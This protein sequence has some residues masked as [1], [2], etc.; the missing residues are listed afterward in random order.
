MS[1]FLF[2][3]VFVPSPFSLCMESTSLVFSFRMMFFYL[4]TTAGFLTSAYWYVKIQSIKGST[5]CMGITF[6]RLCINRVRLPTLLV[7]S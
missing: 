6:S 4:V 2:P 5:V 3:S 1:L 7:V